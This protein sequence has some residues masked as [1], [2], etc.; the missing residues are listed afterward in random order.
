[1]KKILVGIFT[2]TFAWLNA[3][4]KQWTLEE[5][6]SYARQNNLSIQQYLLDEKTA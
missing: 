1:M 5:C 3:Q 4:N 2:L 6:V